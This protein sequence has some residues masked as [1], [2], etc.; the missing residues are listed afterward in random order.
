M[1]DRA[2]YSFYVSTETLW[3]N[4]YNIIL[5]LVCVCEVKGYLP[6]V[7]VLNCTRA[8]LLGPSSIGAGQKGGELS[9]AAY[10]S[11]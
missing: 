7:A 1:L 4:E 11:N 10:S 8:R 5:P 9:F 3:S 6:E 2:V